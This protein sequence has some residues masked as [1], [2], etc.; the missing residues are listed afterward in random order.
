MA[1]TEIKYGSIASSKELNDN[2]EAL[3]KDI[4]D[5][6]TS[7]STTQANLTAS[8]STLNKNV[9]NQIQDVNEALEATKTELEEEI[10]NSNS[11]S[12][13]SNGLYI[14]TYINGSSWYREYFSDKEK[15]NRVWLEQGGWGPYIAAGTTWN[16]VTQIAFLKSF[17]NTSYNVQVTYK[18]EGIMDVSIGAAAYSLDAFQGYTSWAGD[19]KHS[20]FYHVWRACGV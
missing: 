14:T 3:N 12:L 9:T 5:I 16:F 6:A 19:G 8:I 10:A 2:F 11:E 1:I 7:L 17:T 20:G 13:T 15:T 4:Q 18:S